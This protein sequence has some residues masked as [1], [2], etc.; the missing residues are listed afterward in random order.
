MKTYTYKIDKQ[1]IANMINFSLFEE[2]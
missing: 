1:P 2:Y